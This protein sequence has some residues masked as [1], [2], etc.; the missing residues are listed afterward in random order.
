MGGNIGIDLYVSSTPSAAD[1]CPLINVWGSYD[2]PSVA[3]TDMDW[4]LMRGDTASGANVILGPT[5]GSASGGV[6]CNQP[7]HVLTPAAIYKISVSGTASNV[8]AAL[9]YRVF[10]YRKD[11]NW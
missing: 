3:P 6:S 5:K 2:G 10:A 4:T 11:L 1:T 9:R 8:T 7:I